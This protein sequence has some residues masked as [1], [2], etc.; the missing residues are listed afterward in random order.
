QLSLPERG[1]LVPILLASDQTHLTNFS[2]DKKLWPVYMS[3]GNIRSSIR[4]TPTM[5]SWILIVFLPIGSK[6]VKKI[7]GY[8]PDMQE[9]QALQTTHDKGYEMICADDNIRL[10]FPKLF[11]WLANHMENA[12]LHGITSNHCPTCIIPTEKLGEYSE[13]SY[14]TR[15][16]QDYILAYNK[17]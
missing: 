14:L 1:T 7:P 9:I 2:G 8:S 11:C 3:I 13:T 6:R 16:H 15:S 12:T 17:S 4:N 10:C 5:H